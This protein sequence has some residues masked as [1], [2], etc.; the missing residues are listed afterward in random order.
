MSEKT[1]CPNCG[2]LYFSEDVFCSKCGATITEKA[3]NKVIKHVSPSHVNQARI[4]EFKSYIQIIGIVE[5]AFGIL[6]MVGGIFAAVLA[7]FIPSFMENDVTAQGET[8]VASFVTVLFFVLAAILIIF[9]IGSIVY[10]KRLMEY[11]NS[12]RIGTMIIAAISLINIPI[13]TIFG[14]FALYVLTRP[15]VEELFEP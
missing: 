8:D 12:G 15:E 3:P 1:Y 13:G 10:G 5:I 2:S 9:G 11:K 4:N 6:G 14:A 7:A